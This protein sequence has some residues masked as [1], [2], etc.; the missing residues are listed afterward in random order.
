MQFPLNGA[1]YQAPRRQD[2]SY[3]TSVSHEQVAIVYCHI[4]S[5]QSL[6]AYKCLRDEEVTRR[7]CCQ[8]LIQLSCGK[9]LPRNAHQDSQSW[10]K[11][12][13]VTILADRVKILLETPFLTT[14]DATS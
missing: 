9:A 12:A 2:A 10:A 6:R 8:D 7:I 13:S 5:R 14:W 1:L 4:Q 11:A 3:I